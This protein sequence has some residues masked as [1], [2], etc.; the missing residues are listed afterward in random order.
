MRSF[1][2]LIATMA[3]LHFT[4]NP[5]WPQSEREVEAIRESIKKYEAAYNSGDVEYLLSTLSDSL[6][7][8]T[9]GQTTIYG[10]TMKQVFKASYHAIAAAYDFKFTLMPEEI[11]LLG[12]NH[13]VDIG[14]YKL[15]L[16]AK[17]GGEAVV[18][19][20]RYM[21]ILEKKPD[22]LWVTIY[23]MDNFEKPHTWPPDLSMN[24]PEN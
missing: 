13:A 10:E 7:F 9:D 2:T 19:E 1:F 6:V 14:A 24:E 17:G 11:K 21:Q 20:S 18:I 22:G 15:S 12:G 8:M 3:I 5:L 4:Q 23:S 16:T